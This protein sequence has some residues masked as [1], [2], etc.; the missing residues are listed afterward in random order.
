MSYNS[1]IVLEIDDTR[2]TTDTRCE[3]IT[4]LD[5]PVLST[6]DRLVFVSHSFPWE[7]PQIAEEDTPSK[8]LMRILD[9]LCLEDFYFLRLGED[10]GDVEVN[11]EGNTLD[12]GYVEKFTIGV[13]LM[14]I[15]D[16]MKVTLSRPEIKE[17]LETGILESNTLTE[18]ILRETAQRR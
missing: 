7:D 17:I 16:E 13:G 6:N 15:P 8:R 11:G 5:T 3:L 18:R 4:L 12:I 1:K 14:T 9:D 10:A 2:L